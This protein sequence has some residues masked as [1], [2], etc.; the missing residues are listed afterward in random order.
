MGVAN[1]FARIKGNLFV[2]LVKVMS[3]KFAKKLPGH[4]YSTNAEF[5][6]KL[7]S[8][9]LLG[10]GILY[11]FNLLYLTYATA[12]A[13]VSPDPG[14]Y[15]QN[16][17]EIIK[18]FRSHTSLT[19]LA[20]STPERTLIFE[21]PTA[22]FLFLIRHVTK[23]EIILTSFIFYAAIFLSA[24][25]FIARIWLNRKDSVTITISTLPLF[26]SAF[27]NQS[28]YFQ[29]FA[30]LTFLT[31]GEYFF[32]K[33]VVSSNTREKSKYISG[34]LLS[35]F[36]AATI[37][38]QSAVVQGSIAYLV[39]WYF[40]HEPKLSHLSMSR[41]QRARDLIFNWWVFVTAIIVTS[42]T[43]YFSVLRYIYQSFM[44][45][46]G[47]KNSIW[48]YGS[49][50]VELGVKN[51]FIFRL[52]TNTN[53]IALMYLAAWTALFMLVV[54]NDDLKVHYKKFFLCAAGTI[55]LTQIWIVGPIN[56]RYLM[57]VTIEF[58]FF[59]V[60][61]YSKA[62][63]RR[64]IGYEILILSLVAF[65][66]IVRSSATGLTNF[67]SKIESRGIGVNK[68][69]NIDSGVL[70][71]S[72]LTFNKK[73]SDTDVF[74][75]VFTSLNQ[76]LPPVKLFILTPGQAGF[77]G[78]KSANFAE[79]YLQ[80]ANRETSE[81]SSRN[82]VIMGAFPSEMIVPRVAQVYN[83][84]NAIGLSAAN[85]LLRAANGQLFPEYASA[86]NIILN[87]N[88]SS[89]GLTKIRSWTFGSQKYQLFQVVDTLKW[90]HFIAEIFC[91]KQD[92]Y[93]STMARIDFC[94][95]QRYPDKDKGHFNIQPDPNPEF[96]VKSVNGSL[97]DSGWLSINPIQNLKS[98][99]LY[100]QFI[101]QKPSFV[102]RFNYVNY[103]S[104]LGQKTINL[105]PSLINTNPKCDY[106]AR[107]VPQS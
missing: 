24:T 65:P 21:Y 36:L 4:K 78:Y 55:I 12:N 102:C 104:F 53:Q 30:C 93:S 62:S 81:F 8:L 37:H 39:T 85:F 14:F 47:W 41:I 51:K 98:G 82:N 32:I 7:L 35:F 80:F 29:D 27:T 89:Y 96:G 69:N 54:Y 59:I 43:I 87:A 10:S 101:P 72:L 2:F 49:G 38:I 95:K 45:V 60:I 6:K 56:P 5:V 68:A 1:I 75:P 46:A 22:V 44:L 19:T 84:E 40:L 92:K 64:R 61:A 99:N 15:L 70:S 13:N 97:G 50:G 52:F 71:V 28:A 107:I 91:A 67:I 103:W 31:V 25:Y 106:Y 79:K 9:V 76:Q 94:P 48:V 58:V 20:N 88:L 83:H 90:R 73:I 105:E 42:I 16:T 34:F 63:V 77:G 86:S 33:Y 57:P 18:T 66:S 74:T 26:L 100:V 11:S 17:T 3:R 23:R